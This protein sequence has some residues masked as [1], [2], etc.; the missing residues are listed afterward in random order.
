MIGIREGVLKAGNV[1][2]SAKEERIEIY[3]SALREKAQK[4][5]LKESAET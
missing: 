2:H 1:F 5:G 4:G 3:P